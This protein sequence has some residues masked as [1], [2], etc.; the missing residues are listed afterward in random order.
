MFE[1]SKGTKVGLSRAPRD[2]NW[3][4]TRRP[5]NRWGPTSSRP[6]SPR[7]TCASIKSPSRPPRS[8]PLRCAIRPR[9]HR[10]RCRPTSS[11]SRPPRSF[12]ALDGTCPRLHW[13]PSSSD[14]IATT[15]S[16]NA[17]VPDQNIFTTIELD[18]LSRLNVGLDAAGNAMERKP[19]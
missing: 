18:F 7:S 8:H 11:P 19:A 1:P 3:T 16:V 2:V 4:F 17:S 13:A 9:R 15:T 6:R 5:C 10:H 14:F 12:S